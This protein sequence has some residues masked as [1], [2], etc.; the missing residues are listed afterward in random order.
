MLLLEDP[1]PALLPRRGMPCGAATSHLRRFRSAILPGPSQK[2]FY[3]IWTL[4]VRFRTPSIQ[5][6]QPTEKIAWPP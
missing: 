3:A 2:P 5:V 6:V 4:I 1:M